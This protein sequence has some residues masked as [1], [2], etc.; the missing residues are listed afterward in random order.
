MRNLLPPDLLRQVSQLP[1][2]F[3]MMLLNTERTARELED[4]LAS[5]R[6]LFEETLAQIERLT[7]PPSDVGASSQSTCMICLNDFE[8]GDNCRRLPCRHV[9]HGDC[10]DE[11]LR[12]CTDCP[13]CKANV[14][15]AV[16]Q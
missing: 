14:D 9:F 15:R 1:A 11:W 2:G 4:F 8:I 12:R 16:R 10:V 13:I 5:R 3:Q 6:G 7:W